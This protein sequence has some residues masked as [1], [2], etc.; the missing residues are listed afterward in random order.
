M[1]TDNSPYPSYDNIM[2]FAGRI[3]VE[4][5]SPEILTTM[6]AATIILSTI[7]RHAFTGTDH[8][9]DPDHSSFEK[10]CVGAC[11]MAA[12][13]VPLVYALKEA[14]IDLDVHDL[15]SNTGMEIF[16]GY[17]QTDRQTIIDEGILLFQDI[18][19]QAGNNTKLEEWMTSIHTVTNK[20]ITTLGD[21]EYIELFAPL[22]L[23]LLMA[24]RQ[25]TMQIK[26]SQDS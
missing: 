21:T 6:D 17:H 16:R 5:G 13:S 8:I 12:C 22:Y 25:F 26:T 3:Q 11:F 18:T 19:R 1:S 10:S 2:D 9:P 4:S 14:D 7:T 15:M 24:T 20:Y 23:V